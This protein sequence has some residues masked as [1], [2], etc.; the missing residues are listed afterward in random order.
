MYLFRK[1]LFAITFAL[2]LAATVQAQSLDRAGGNPTA[3]S[4]AGAGYYLTPRSRIP[5]IYKSVE[6]SPDPLERLT[7]AGSNLQWRYRG[8]L[9]DLARLNAPVRVI[10]TIE[11][12]GGILNTDQKRQLPVQ[13]DG[14]S[15]FNDP[16]VQKRLN[17]TPEQIRQ[18]NEANA[19]SQQQWEEINNTGET[20]FE[21]GLRL[22]Q[23]YQRDY[24]HRL[25]KILSPEQLKTW[26]GMTGNRSRSQPTFSTTAPRR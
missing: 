2:L 8:D 23:N 7:T 24:Q 16:G 18:L 12:R 20:D 9:E 21:A 1:P 25:N 26:Q 3:S 15:S 5:G 19:W 13:D 11:V 14:F 10:R 6:T 17:L 22:Y 4:A